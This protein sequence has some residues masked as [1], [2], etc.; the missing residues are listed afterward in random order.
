MSPQDRTPGMFRHAHWVLFGL[1]ISLAVSFWLGGARFGK[2][3]EDIYRDPHRTAAL[4]TFEQAIVFVPSGAVHALPTAE[5]L[6]RKFPCA[7]DERISRLAGQLQAIE[8]KLASLSRGG[9]S[10]LHFSLERWPP[11]GAS[12]SGVLEAAAWLAEDR[13][14]RLDAMDWPG[15]WRARFDTPMRVPDAVFAQDNPWRGADGCVYLG[16]TADGRLLYLEENRRHQETCPAMAGIDK[17]RTVGVSRK[18]GEWAKDDP[19]WA[20]PDDLGSI[21]ADLGRIRRPEGIA[22]GLY[23]QTP[24]PVNDNENGAAPDRPR[25]HGPN[26]IALH[27]RETDVGFNVRLTIDPAAQ[28]LVQQWARCYAGDTHA[29]DLL[30]LD[31]NDPLLDL[32]GDMYESAAVRMAAVAL[33]DV[34]SGRIEALGSAHTPCYVQDHDGP[35]HA[36]GCPDAPF[37]PRY[38]RDRLL[39]HALFVDAM[40]A[41]T[42]KPIMALGFLMD[43][44]AY[45]ARPALDDL[46]QDLKTSD[47]AAFLDR[48]FCGREV[49]AS[50]RWRDCQRPQRVQEAAR[51]L[52]WN[53]ECGRDNFSPDCAKLDVL[54]GRPAGRRLVAE[55][56][57]QPLGKSLLYG[58]LF[59]EPSGAQSP[60]D[61]AP[62]SAWAA[63]A[64][65]AGWGGFRLIDEFRFDESF[66]RECS[67]GRFCTDC[68]AGHG[69]WRR[70]KGNG[71][72]IANEGW[73]QGEARATPLGVAGMIARMAAAANGAAAQAYP[74]LVDHIGDAAGRRF[75]MSGLAVYE[76]EA[77]AAEGESA[78][79][80]LAGMTSHKSGGTANDSCRTIFGSKPACDAI[81]WIAGKTGTPPFHFD[82]SALPQ[83]KKACSPERDKVDADCNTIP[84]KWYV[85]AFKTQGGAEAPFDKAIAVLS[86]RN[87]RKK[88]G[89]VQSPGDKEANL[90]AELAFRIVKALRQESESPP[91]AAN[92]KRGRP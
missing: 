7:G 44:P 83:I 35:G 80:V 84:Y 30:G 53:L 54:F 6:R 31:R 61:D 90:S 43:T 60:A 89:M 85:A 47:S 81:D 4:K 91:P 50:R 29:C 67:E 38:D 79:L 69:R 9:R 34:A 42:V 32:A 62:K 58:Q 63:L 87:W 37:R 40:P 33:I 20:V 39:N 5:E 24:E 55:A 72:K 86:E 74:H 26:R 15:L 68:A 27:G 23:T 51:Q 3:I 21:L 11:E 18:K 16:P 92:K 88:N 56:R 13:G 36:A 78:A 25:S 75:E 41:S 48:L 46:W 14:R 82:Q 65:A 73:G 57:K 66:A 12:C 10:T 28:G 49:D 59:V 8:A 64:P 1:V 22:Y 76:P 2:K 77:I 71:G 17:A 19:A 45:R 52:G 70:C